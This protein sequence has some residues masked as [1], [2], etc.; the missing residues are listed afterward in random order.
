[1]LREKWITKRIHFP[2]LSDTTTTQLF[3]N[4][5]SENKEDGWWELGKQR[6]LVDF[7]GGSYCGGWI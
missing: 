2:V 1:V 3:G 6:E 7:T 4:S 5:V